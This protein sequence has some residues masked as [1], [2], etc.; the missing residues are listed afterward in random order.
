MKNTNYLIHLFF[1]KTVLLTGQEVASRLI[2][3]SLSNKWAFKPHHIPSVNRSEKNKL[4]FFI[5]YAFRILC[6][7]ASIIP[8]VFRNYIAIYLNLGQSWNSILRDGIP[9]ILLKLFRKNIPIVISLHGHWFAEWPKR[10]RKM[11]AF[12]KTLS[13]AKYVIVLSESQ[14]QLLIQYGLKKEAIRVIPNTCNFKPISNDLLNAKHLSPNRLKILFFSNLISSKGYKEF[15]GAI[16]IL[17]YSDFPL[18][19]QAILCGNVMEAG[20]SKETIDPSQDIEN[21]I[22]E[23]NNNGQIKIQWLKGAYGLEKIQLFKEAH[24]FIF[25]SRIEAQPIVL[26]EAMASGCTIISSKAG[27]IPSMLSKETAMLMNDLNSETIANLTAD[28]INDQNKRISLSSA[29]LKRFT[30]SFSISKYQQNWHNLF[31]ELSN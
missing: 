1:P 30:D 21:I 31:L 18:P 9:F 11:R 12:L 22:S 3:E 5:K 26:I 19:V 16:Q 7:W 29:A 28:L 10:G 25:P 23:I 8:L 6:L 2:L 17:K 4:C 15:L 14:K 20:F 13:V 24:I 27:L